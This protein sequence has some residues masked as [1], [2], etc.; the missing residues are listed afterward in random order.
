M[1]QSGLAFLS[2]CASRITSFLLLLYPTGQAGIV[3][4]FFAFGICIAGRIRKIVY[5]I[6][7]YHVT[8]SFAFDVIFRKI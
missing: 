8:I 6:V 3:S 1:W 7:L 4:I 5:Q 2:L